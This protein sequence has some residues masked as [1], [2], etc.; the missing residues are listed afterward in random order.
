MSAYT[1]G[2]PALNNVNAPAK[3]G[4]LFAAATR[5]L[6]ARTTASEPSPA[7]SSSI[8]LKPP[9][10]PRACTGGGGIVSTP[11]SLIAERRARGAGNT[12]VAFKP[13]ISWGSTEARLG[14]IIDAFDPTD[15]VDAS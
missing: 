8:I 4:S 15:V 12:M 2:D 7:R 9:A 10:V 1:E 11:A 5:S 6:A 14:Q 3:C 13:G